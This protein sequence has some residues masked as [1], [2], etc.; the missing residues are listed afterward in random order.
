MIYPQISLL[1][2]YMH[3]SLTIHD[4]QIIG[5]R[6]TWQRLLAGDCG[7]VNILNRD[8]RYAHLPCQIAATVPAG[9]KAEGGWDASEWLAP[10][11]RV[12]S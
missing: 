3:L 12:S 6:Q 8:E 10:G 2:K 5:I 11:V 7:I 4:A 1:P 9:K